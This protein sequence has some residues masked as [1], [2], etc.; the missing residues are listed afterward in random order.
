MKCALLTIGDEICTGQV[1]NTNAHW[2][3]NYITELGGEV[4]EHVSIYDDIPEIVHCLKR[5]SEAFELVVVTGGLGPTHDDVTKKALCQLT[6]EPLRR[7]AHTMAR[8]TE[9]WASRD[10]S[11]N[12]RQATQAD[13]PES[14][15]VVDNA[16]GTAPGM[17]IRYNNCHIF[18]LPGVP[19]EMKY[20]MQTGGTDLVQSLKSS[21]EVVV[22]KTF[23]TSGKGESDLSEIVGDNEMFPNGVTIAYLPNIAGVRVRLTSRAQSPSQAHQ[24]LV[25]AEQLLIERAGK[26]VF[27]I[28]E[29]T[30]HGVVGLMLKQHGLTIATAESCTSGMLGAALTEIHGSSQWY[31][32]GV[33]VYSNEAKVSMCGVSKD[34]LYNHGAVSRETA[35]E[36]AAGIRSNLKT[37]IGV[38]ITGIAGPG[39]GTPT[40]PVGTIWVGINGP[41]EYQHELLLKL[42]RDRIQNRKRSVAAALNLIRMTIE[43]ELPA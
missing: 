24:Q 17:I 38:S 26:Y 1:L 6:N 19:M 10:R 41:G 30:L 15:Q 20:L 4:L 33:N 14:A 34:T 37:D 9:F 13:V 11:M 21:N 35:R 43:Q 23:L 16:V 3:A 42:G 39:G 29:D 32:G 7:D 36:L 8:L 25:R 40:K 12:E 5:L 28:R 18:S 27:G 31:Q 2:L 22:R